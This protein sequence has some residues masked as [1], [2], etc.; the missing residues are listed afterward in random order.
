MAIHCVALIL[1]AILLACDGPGGPMGPQGSP[2]TQ[3]EQGETGEKGDPGEPGEQ[4]EKG[5]TGPPGESAQSL[6]WADVIEATDIDDAIYAIGYSIFF[7]GEWFDFLIG[8]GFSAHFSDVIWTNAHVVN[9]LNDVIIDLAGWNPVPFAVKSGTVMGGNDY[10]ELSTFFT[11]P[12]YD[13]TTASPDVAVLVINESLDTV[14]QFLPRE[15]AVELRVGQPV[16]TMGFPGEIAP[17]NTT[18]PIA[19]FKNGTISA[20]RP[21]NPTT[22][23]VTPGNNRFVQHSLD[24]SGGTSGSPIFDHQG[25][26]IAVNNSG[27]EALTLNLNTGE[28]SRVPTGNIGF[29]IRADDVWDFIDT[30]A[31][32]K[33]TALLVP[34]LEPAWPVSVGPLGRYDPFPLNWNGAT[35]PPLRQAAVH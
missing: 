29:G 10:Y 3:G 11:H 26:I 16:G 8:T 25:W 1:T 18:V 2:G 32:D 7:D 19:T 27:T 31:S 23:E 12:E 35:I 34:K 15:M 4:G 24:L 30:F 6:N 17:L 13:G 21:Y 5:D 14:P 33:R 9:G 28:P 20:L 22:T